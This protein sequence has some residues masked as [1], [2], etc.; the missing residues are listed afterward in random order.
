MEMNMFSKKI[1]RAVAIAIATAIV[2]EMP[3]TVY[4][5]KSPNVELTDSTVSSVVAK[6]HDENLL[7]Q[8][9]NVIDI[10]GLFDKFE[11]WYQ[12][13]PDNMLVPLQKYINQ[14]RDQNKIEV[15][16]GKIAV[17]NA[18]LKKS[19]ADNQ[20]TVQFLSKDNIIYVV[21]ESEMWYEAIC[22]D[23]IGYVRKDCVKLL[24]EK[25][26]N[27]QNVGKLLLKKGSGIVT[28]VQTKAEEEVVETKKTSSTTK[29]SASTNKKSNPKTNNKSEAPES[30]SS[31][32][33][34]VVN[35]AEQYLGIPYVSGGTTPK[36]FDC[37]GF[38]YYVFN[39]IDYPLS[40]SMWDQYKAGTKVSKSNL[41]PGDLVFFK[42]THKSGMSHVGIY[43]GNGKFI[44]SPRTGK[45]VSYSELNSDYWEQHYYGACRIKG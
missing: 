18:E 20:K 37:S 17:T 8:E 31:F 42:N 38:V 14:Q 13:G 23:Q 4:A 6:S 24:E 16:Y 43:V 22:N 30:N 33:A 21:G 34:K 3:L 10:A 26:T 25:P 12:S 32:G 2:W 7:K 9:A 28:K 29:K 36:G 35:K 27:D 15:G 11:S 39:Q 41:Q 1:K 45:N 5:T 40:R 19:A 44:H